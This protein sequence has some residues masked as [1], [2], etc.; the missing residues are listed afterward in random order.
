[1]LAKPQDTTGHTAAKPQDVAPHTA[2]KPQDVAPHTAIKPQDTTPSLV[3]TFTTKIKSWFANENWVGVNLF[4][5]LGAMLLI[6]GTIAVAAFE[7]FHPLLRTS[8]LFALAFTV[9]IL[10]ELMNRKKPTIFST[11]LSAT[12]VA[13][14]YIAIAA[15]FFALETLGMY[16]ALIACILATTLGIFLATRYNAQ[17]IGCFALIGGYLPIFALDP[18]NNTIM[19]GVMVYFIILSLFSLTLAL[20]RKW[21]TMNI[22]GFILTVLGASYLGWQAAPITALIYAC[23]AF[24]LYTALPLIATYRTK[25][26]F[27][28]L[29]VW[30]IILNTFISSIVIFLIANRLELQNLHAFL[31]L[32]FG[33]IYAIVAFLTNPLFKHKGI[34]TLFI[35]TSIA[36]FVLFVPFYF[37]ARWFATMW[38]LQAVII[39]C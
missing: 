31:C 15:S 4:N 35:L 36:F 17:V 16:T 30:L 25:A 18:F 1:M 26:K 20:S 23:F 28:D 27:T 2:T 12:G 6:I 22:I 14:S 11:G 5:R 10:A 24:L 19:V 39:A 9:I 8:V 34:N 32:A 37:S 21:S 38:L 7:G 3:T 29:D 13:L 33:L